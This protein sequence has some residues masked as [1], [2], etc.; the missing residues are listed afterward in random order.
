MSEA[1]ES[2]SVIVTTGRRKRAS[3]RVRLTPGTGEFTINGRP[4]ATYCCHETLVRLATGPLTTVEAKEQF[5]VRVLVTGGGLQGQATAIAHGVA[6]ALE[7]H[8]PE[9]RIPLKRAGHLKRDPRRRE[10]KKPGQP[11]ARKRFQFSKR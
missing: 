11:G 7:R 6:R 5:D 4:L 10:R 8:D 9:W 1:T 2:T 3:A